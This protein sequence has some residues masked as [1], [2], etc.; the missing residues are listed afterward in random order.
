[1]KDK[2]L[3][4]S[5]IVIFGISGMSV[6]LLA[7]L[8]AGMESQRIMGTLVGLAGVTIAFF[9]YM[10]L[11]KFCRMEAKRVTVEVEAGNKR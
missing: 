6:T 1:M 10:S 4:I 11:K 5:L 7:W 3:E 8:W 2:S 9:K